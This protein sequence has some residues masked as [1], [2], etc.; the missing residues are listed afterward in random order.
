MMQNDADLC[1]MFNLTILNFNGIKTKMHYK[2]WLQSFQGIS[3]IKTN[4]T[5]V[6]NERN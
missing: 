3:V 1:F 2:M 4:S 5:F 6:E